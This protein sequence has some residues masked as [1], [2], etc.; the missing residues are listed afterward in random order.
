MLKENDNL[1][2]IKVGGKTKNIIFDNHKRNDPGSGTIYF[3]IIISFIDSPVR[4]T[5]NNH[6]TK[7]LWCA[8]P[9]ES[10]LARLNKIGRNYL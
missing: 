7:G 10:G 4:D 3:V 1:V 6:S 8:N 2:H 9:L 5:I